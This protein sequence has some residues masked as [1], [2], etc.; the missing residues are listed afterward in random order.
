MH[1]GKE[2]L[3]EP[4]VQSILEALNTRELLKIRVLDAAPL[5]AGATG[6]KLLEEIDDAA[7]V[8]VIGHVIVIYRPFPEEPEIRIP[9]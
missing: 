9:A 7:L 8:Q 4:A 6:R 5:D 3:N 2:G 1:V